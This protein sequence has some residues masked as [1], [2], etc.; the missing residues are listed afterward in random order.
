MVAPGPP[1][2]RF[3]WCPDAY[4]TCGAAASPAVS[5]PVL[6][7][8]SAIKARPPGAADQAS[9]RGISRA[10]RADPERE[11]RYRHTFPVIRGTGDG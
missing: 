6:P 2:H 10:R 11:A 9:G 1:Q 7:V 5:V 8:S 4:V 3:S